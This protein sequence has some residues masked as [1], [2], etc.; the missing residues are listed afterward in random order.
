MLL[1]ITR[2]FSRVMDI[3]TL[4]RDS[5]IIMNINIFSNRWFNLNRDV[6]L[7]RLDISA[8]KSFYL[9]SYIYEIHPALPVLCRHDIVVVKE[10]YFLLLLGLSHC[11]L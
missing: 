9:G 8:A 5:K 6:L 10:E 1:R 2:V 4:I 3:V 11:I 7:Y